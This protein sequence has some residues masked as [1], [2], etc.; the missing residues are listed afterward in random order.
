MKQIEPYAY[1]K[2]ENKIYLLEFSLDKGRYELIGKYDNLFDGKDYA[3]LADYNSSYFTAVFV[4][5]RKIYKAIQGNFVGF[6]NGFIYFENEDKRL[7]MLSENRN[8]T[9]VAHSCG[10]STKMWE[11][12]YLIFKLSDKMKVEMNKK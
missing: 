1:L 3:V 7:F 10:I 4:K 12:E 9:E 8:I 2:K 11:N 5:Q 6:G